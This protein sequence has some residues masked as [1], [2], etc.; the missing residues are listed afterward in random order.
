MQLQSTIRH[1]WMK[2]TLHDAIQAKRVHHQLLP[3]LIQYESGF[4]EKI[5]LG[6]QA[7]GH[8]TAQTQVTRGFSAVTAISKAFNVLEV[9]ADA[10]RNGST[11]I[12]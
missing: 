8:I 6:L 11:A 3:M 7:L 5:L 4:D 12:F 2:D 10:R 1:L 9:S